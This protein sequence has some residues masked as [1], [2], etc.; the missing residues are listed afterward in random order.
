MGLRGFH[1]RPIEGVAS[2]HL[3]PNRIWYR[4][5]TDTEDVANVSTDE[6]MPE[7]RPKQ[8]NE[9]LHVSSADGRASSD[10]E[11]DSIHPSSVD[12]WQFVSSPFT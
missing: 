12:C 1:S 7:P 9:Q 4:S 11:M 5:E 8:P 10:I 3:H 6:H 2:L